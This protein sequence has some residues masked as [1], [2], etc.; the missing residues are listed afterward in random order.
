MSRQ[1]FSLLELS[2]V[3]T[4]IAIVVA[5]GLTLSTAKTQQ[6]KMVNSYDEL[7]E[8]EKAMAVY[9]NTNGCLPY[10]APVAATPGSATYGREPVA[11]AKC[12]TTGGAGLVLEGAV[13]F[14]S[15]GLPDEYSA[16]DW[17]T[18][19]TYAVT[20]TAVESSFS[21]SA[22]GVITVQDDGLNDISTEVAYVLLSHGKTRKGGYNV[23]TG[24]ATAACEATENDGE[25]C[26]GDD[27]FVDA[28]YNDGDVAAS[29]FDDIVIW[30]T[31]TGVYSYTG[32]SGSSSG[33]Y[34][35]PTDVKATTS[36]NNGDFGGY[37]GVQTFI[38]ANGCAGYKV[39]TASDLA[40]YSFD[41]GIVASGG[42]VGGGADCDG[43]TS[44]LG[45]VSGDIFKGGVGYIQDY[46]CDSPLAV[47]CC[48]WD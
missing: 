39:C 41:N 26:D 14:Y 47:A 44:S 20:D 12:A 46:T 2:I 48:K 16:D 15:L 18:R 22:T 31:V 4:I 38:E 25:N 6:L 43:W 32:S 7:K 28:A 8:I 42:W 35:V 5:S 9:V 11:N 3:L 36:T 1:G 27:T 10:P 19:Y 17:N 21:S 23:K 40:R 24:A 29:F 34:P 30:N 13:P 45:A 33:G 37:A